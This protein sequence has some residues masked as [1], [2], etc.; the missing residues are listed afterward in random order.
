MWTNDLRGTGWLLL[1]SSSTFHLYVVKDVK[2]R[3]VGV[4][5]CKKQFTACHILEEVC[6]SMEAIA[7]KIVEDF[8]PD[9]LIQGL[10]SHT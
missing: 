3:C 2:A 7:G 5:L 10:W 8:G 9:D 4:L 1:Y 6:D